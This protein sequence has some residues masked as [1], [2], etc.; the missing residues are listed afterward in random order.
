MSA[1]LNSCSS[2]ESKT[3]AGQGLLIA[4]AEH[5]SRDSIARTLYHLPSIQ[6]KMLAQGS[7][8]RGSSPRG[9]SPRGGSPR[10]AG[11]PSRERMVQQEYWKEH[12]SALDGATVEAMMLDSQVRCQMN[13]SLPAQ[14]NHCFDGNQSI[15]WLHNSSMNNLLSFSPQKILVQ[16]ASLDLQER[17]EV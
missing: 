5:C 14:L 4:H 2:G 8:P 3:T 7:S 17:P 12:T 6:S 11:S 9:G 15:V 16:A 13:S 1:N 10:R